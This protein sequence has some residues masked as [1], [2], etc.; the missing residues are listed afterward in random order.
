MT[1]LVF[2]TPPTREANFWLARI[3]VVEKNMSLALGWQR[4]CAPKS[5]VR[6]NNENCPWFTIG[7]SWCILSDVQT[8][9]GGEKP[10]RQQHIRNKH[11]QKRHSR[12]RGVA[13][14]ENVTRA[15]GAKHKKKRTAPRVRTRLLVF[16]TPP[17]RE[18]EHYR[19]T[20]SCVGMAH[21][22]VARFLTTK[23]RIVTARGLESSANCV[24]LALQKRGVSCERG[25]KS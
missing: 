24:L 6:E 12:T 3:G 23:T 15:E 5:R 19:N 10:G 22:C 7:N 13:N 9:A 11:L 8:D 2:S 4:Q 16:Y 14:F 21:S 1:K 17:R 20:Y 25:S 18:Q